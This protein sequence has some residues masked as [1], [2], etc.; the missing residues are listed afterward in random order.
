M[1]IHDRDIADTWRRVAGLPSRRSNRW[2]ISASFPAVASWPAPVP[3][4]V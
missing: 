4:G 2:K 1:R 3:A